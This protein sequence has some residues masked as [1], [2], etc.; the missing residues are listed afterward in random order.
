MGVAVLKPVPDLGT[1]GTYESPQAALDH[2]QQMFSSGNSLGTMRALTGLI[3]ILAAAQQ[4][5]DV[6]VGAADLMAQL[7]SQVSF[8]RLG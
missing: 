5:D 1:R 8:P 4:L 6:A 7:M 3:E 2:A